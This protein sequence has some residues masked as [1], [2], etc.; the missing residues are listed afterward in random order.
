MTEPDPPVSSGSVPQIWGDIP[1]R[2]KNFTGRDAILSLLRR[3]I[4]SRVTAVVPED[5]LPRALQGLGGVGKTAVAIEYAHRYRGD[6]DVVW[7]ISADQ[8]PLVRASLAALALRLGLTESAAATGIEGAAKAALDA[9]RRGRPYSR[10]LLIFDNA[11]QPEDFP[12]FIPEGPGDVLITSRNHRW[13]GRA[14]TVQMNVFSRTE[15]MEFL[16]KRAPIEITDREA[17]LLAEK[18]G[19][20]PLAL[21]QAGA[22][23]AETGMPIEE[24]LKLIEEQIVKIMAEGKS[25]EYGTSVTAAWAVSVAKVRQQLPQAEEL[26]RSCAFFGPEPIPRDVF[27]RGT[28]ATSTRISDLM[29][30]S[31]L[32]AQAIRELG[33]FALVTIGGRSISVHRLVQA[34]LRGELNAA[35]QDRYRHDIHLILAAAA[36]PSPADDR[37]WERYRE[38]LPHVTAV[39]TEFANC[40]VAEVRSLALDV[41]RYLYL[42][43]DHRSCVDMS[44]SFIKQWTADSGADDPAVIDANRHY[45]NALRGVGRNA[46]AFALNEQNLDRARHV[47]GPSDAVTLSIQTSV[48][49]DQ[50]ARGNFTVARDIDSE[51][52]E[53]SREALGE[54][55]PQTIRT[56]SNLAID[57][58]LNSDYQRAQELSQLAHQLVSEATAGVS[59]NDVLISWYQMAWALRLQGK[60]QAARDVG[61]DALDYGRERLGANHQTTVRT[62]TGLSVSLRRIA[63]TRET[64]VELARETYELARNRYGE[65]H[66]DAMAVVT[67]LSNSLRTVG[68]FDEALVLADQAAAAYAGI[69]GPEHPYNYGSRAN[70]ALMRR[71]TNHPEEARRLDEEALAGL[72]RRLGGNHDYTLLVAINLA[73]DLAL[74]GEVAA[75]CKLGQETRHRLVDLLGPDDQLSLACAANLALDLRA[76][77]AIADA[78]ELHADTLRRYTAFLGASHPDTVVAAGGGRIDFD[79]D[80]VPL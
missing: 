22:M 54:E 27:R 70:L 21:E 41:M 19:D 43:G 68:Q 15:S 14:E 7:W 64:A 8:L 46:D 11:D 51:A 32:F 65:G 35:E 56:L 76:E 39:A 52:L 33:R 59:P 29:Q 2:N 28:R 57:Y 48:A 26:L 47:L 42:V 40:T 49:A 77:G 9:L 38:L 18:L 37:Y 44:R 78:D 75:A 25:A 24:Y 31:I 63:A 69:Y 36:P 16:R 10:W 60:H 34:L 62:A 50:R 72:T 55:N 71:V 13:G 58:G 20:L 61:E 23:L 6:Y 3:S 4:A 79:F 74:L 53:L 73:S 66:P 12:E 45:G 67:S 1:Q 80:P 5:P 17:D 30:D